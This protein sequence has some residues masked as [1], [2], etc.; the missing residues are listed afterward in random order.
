MAADSYGII[1]EKNSSLVATRSVLHF[2]PTAKVKRLFSFTGA[3]VLLMCSLAFL[4]VRVQAQSTQPLVNPIDTVLEYKPAPGQFMNTPYS[5]YVKGGGYAAVLARA[6]E[7]VQDNKI[8]TL[9]GWGGYI[10]VRLKQPIIN[11]PD[12]PDFEV[13]GNVMPEAGGLNSAEPG[14]IM[15]MEDVNA[16]GLPDDEWCEIRGSEYERSTNQYEITY[17]KPEDPLGEIHWTDNQGGGGTIKRNP[18]HT[19]NSYYPAWESR[20]KIVLTGRLLPDNVELVDNPSDPSSP[21][22]NLKPFDYGYADNHPWG[23]DKSG[24]DLD[25]AVG[26]DGTPRTLS[27]AHFVKVYTGVNRDAGHLGELSTEFGGIRLLELHKKE[28]PIDT[29]SLQGVTP[30]LIRVEVSGNSLV[31]TASGIVNGSVNVYG[32]NGTCYISAVL[33]EGRAILPVSPL[34]GNKEPLIVVLRDRDKVLSWC[35]L[36]F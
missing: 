21:L 17:Y 36:C 2:I 10:V 19:D 5:P 9:G 28:E 7:M 20:S 1:M 32:I 34:E 33:Q 12:Q 18:F 13:S 31:V 27:K 35:K 6:N 29:T 11:H 15:V 22:F 8:I 23:T 30:N 14:I 24:I 25:T 4:F 26:A 3:R 16:N